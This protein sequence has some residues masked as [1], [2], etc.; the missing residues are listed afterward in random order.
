MSSKWRSLNLIEIKM[1]LSVKFHI[2]YAYRCLEIT[3]SELKDL[4][5]IWKN[6]KSLTSIELNLSR[7]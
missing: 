4:T 7:Y 3:D 1:E 6:L 2:Y 5:N